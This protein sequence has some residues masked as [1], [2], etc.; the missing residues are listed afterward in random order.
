MAVDA[1]NKPATIV[2][3]IELS[4]SQTEMINATFDKYDVDGSGS[5]DAKELAV[6][7]ENLMGKKP[8]ERAVEDLLTEADKNEDGVISSSE[9]LAMIAQ[10]MTMTTHWGPMASAISGYVGFDM[11]ASQVH[12]R[13]VQAGFQ[14]NIMTAGASGLGKSTMV[15]TLF[16]GALSR[17][18]TGEKSVIPKT[19]EIGQVSHV[20]EEKGIRLRLTIVDTPGFGDKIDNSNAWKPLVDYQHKQ[21]ERYYTEEQ[22]FFRKRELPDTRVHCLLYFIAPSGHMLTPFDIAA[23]KELSLYYNIVPVIAK[24]DSM[25]VAERE[26]FRKRVRADFEHNDVHVYPQIEDEDDDEEIEHK[27]ALYQQ[28]PFAVVGSNEMI[29][30]GDKSVLGRKLKFSNIEIENPN[31]CEYV[32]LRDMI[33]RERMQDLIETTHMGQ[34]GDYRFKRI[35]PDGAAAAAVTLQTIETPIYANGEDEETV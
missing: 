21:F 24:S 28:L 30:I 5:I 17:A 29:N 19:V 20:I 14:F 4:G 15:D 32:N 18:R 12:K 9:F 23:M 3:R 35:D 1:D 6:M 26:A 22:A 2:S 25:T 33:I 8:T 27:E 13:K 11:L 10:Q 34:Y 7:I 31:H 16:G